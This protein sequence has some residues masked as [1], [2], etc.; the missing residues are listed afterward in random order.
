VG[1]GLW[2]KAKASARSLLFDETIAVLKGDERGLQELL[3]GTG[4]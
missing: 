2:I 3:R 4:D 1:A